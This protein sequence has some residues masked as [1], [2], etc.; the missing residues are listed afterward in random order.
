MHV[1]NMYI[2]LCICFCDCLSLFVCL[3]TNSFPFPLTTAPP[4]ARCPSS[5]PGAPPACRSWR[6]GRAGSGAGP[7]TWRHRPGSAPTW[8][9]AGWVF[10]LARMAR[11][12][13]DTF[14]AMWTKLEKRKVKKVG[15]RDKCYQQEMREGSREP[16]HILP[17]GPLVPTAKPAN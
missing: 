16:S 5:V 6:S 1:S 9:D 12:R 7:R 17:G 8:P 13:K 2:H 10:G 11:T 4:R 3:F 15:L 14:A